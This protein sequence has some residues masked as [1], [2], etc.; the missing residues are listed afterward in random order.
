M[1]YSSGRET[2][3]ARLG[4]SKLWKREE[5]VFCGKKLRGFSIATE[6]DAKNRLYIHLILP[7]PLRRVQF[8]LEVRTNIQCTCSCSLSYNYLF[9]SYISRFV[10]S[11]WN[12]ICLICLKAQISLKIFLMKR[13]R[14]SIWLTKFQ[15]CKWSSAIEISLAFLDATKFFRSNWVRTPLMKKHKNRFFGYAQKL[16][17]GSRRKDK[18]LSSQNHFLCSPAYLYRS[19]NDSRQKKSK[20]TA[21]VFVSDCDIR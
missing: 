18:K 16:H 5:A 14:L 11:P 12:I 6:I 9:Y 21:E 17:K 13:R 10:L 1:T 19:K 15:T 4:M 2:N 7:L 8:C 3:Q 20:L